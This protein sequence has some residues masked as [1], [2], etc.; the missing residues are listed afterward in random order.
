MKRTHS[1]VVS[2]FTCRI[3]LLHSLIF[4][5]HTRQIDFVLAYPQADIE[6]PLY[7]KLPHGIK[8]K[9]KHKKTHV[10]KLR[11]NLYGQ[12]QAGRVWFKHLTSKL[13]E[14]GFQPSSCDDCLY[15]RG[16]T[17]FFFYVDDGVFLSPQS[18]DVDK[19]IDDLKLT[20]LNL[21][22]RGDMADYLGI[23]FSHEKDNTISMRQPHLIQQI[24]NA[25]RIKPNAHLPPTPAVSSYILKRDENAPPFASAWNFRSI[26]GM[27]NYLE[28]GTRP[29]I[30]YATHQCAK[31]TEDPRAP[32]A[33]AVEHI[34][35]YLQRTS[36]KGII[37]K[38]DTTK[39][40]EVFA[41][42]DFSGN[43]YKD[44]AQHDASTVKS[45]TGFIIMYAGC[46]VVWC[47]KLQTQ[48]T[49]ST[50]EAEY[51]SLSHALR[52]AIPLINLL[53][54]MQDKNISTVSKTPTVFCKAFE[55]NSGALELAKSPK[56]RPRTKHINLPY[57]HFREHVRKRIIQL[58]PISTEF[59]LAD[60]FTKP[61]PRDLFERFR[62]SIMGW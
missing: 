13:K 38:P 23:N 40:L 43:W 4:R 41:D 2:W 35:K 20:G 61:L 17:M 62:K 46:P 29:D 47:S 58:F 42:A 51:I 6:Q 53:K 18:T 32:H 14:I 36:D 19:A 7:M 12:R 34:V 50:T 22:D 16:S 56:L 26:I 60:I 9:N 44:T 28:K 39:S 25:V 37:L 5:W 10:L 31:F 33:K 54:E 55:D 15:Y 59:Q 3:L 30:G 24:I 27:L 21:E 8:V 48:V 52:E 11:K 45:R 57:H 49:L 1:P